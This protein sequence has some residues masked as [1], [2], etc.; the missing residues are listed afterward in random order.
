MSSWINQP[1][2]ST[3]AV[4]VVLCM[5]NSVS[6]VP[7]PQAENNKQHINTDTWCDAKHYLYEHI[8]FRKS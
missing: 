2:T 6:S 3:E 4:T 5:Q 1:V 8:K 7:V